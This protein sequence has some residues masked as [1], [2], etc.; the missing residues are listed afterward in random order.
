MDGI[1][2]WEDYTYDVNKFVTEEKWD[3]LSLR[4]ISDKITAKYRDKLNWSIVAANW[5]IN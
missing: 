2:D 4:Y 3:D 5:A 1:D